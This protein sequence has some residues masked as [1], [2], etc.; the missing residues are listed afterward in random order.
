MIKYIAGLLLGV[1]FVLYS[2]YRKKKQEEALSQIRL[3]QYKKV[4]FFKH[5]SW[6]LVVLFVFALFCLYFGIKEDNGSLVSV[7]IAIAIEAI[8][9]FIYNKNY[10]NFYYNDQRCIIDGKQVLYSNIKRCYK[11]SNIPLAKATVELYSGEKKS[12]YP[13]ALDL[14]KDKIK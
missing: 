7:S 14:I 8:S 3:D 9:E 2:V 11:N 5:Y 4:S 6:L 12:L 1:V 10:M 13:Y